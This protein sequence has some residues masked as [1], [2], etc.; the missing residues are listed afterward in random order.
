[1]DKKTKDFVFSFFLTALGIYFSIEGYAIYRR[2]AGPPYRIEKFSLSPG[3]L[4]FVLGLALIFFSILLFFSTMKGEKNFGTTFVNRWKETGKWYADAVRNKEYLF[5]IGG[6]IIMMIYTYL[7]LDILPFWAASIIFL[8]AIYL[9]LRAG[10]WWK[11]IIVAVGIVILTVIVFKYC[12][13]AA[14]P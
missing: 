6:I 14:L 13:N 9:Y 7:L 5:T 12:F 11:S 2:V 1:M 3:F 10:K 4:P 8:V